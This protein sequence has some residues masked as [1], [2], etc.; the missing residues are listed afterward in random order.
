MNDNVSPDFLKWLQE[1]NGM[2][3][4]DYLAESEWLQNEFL[5]DYSDYLEEIENEEE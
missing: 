4:E 5:A 3:L 1:T 2:S